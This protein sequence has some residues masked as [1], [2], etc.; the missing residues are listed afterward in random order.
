MYAIILD[1]N[2]QYLIKENTL[3]KIDFLNDSIGNK[4][5]I[6]KILFLNNNNEIFI[7]KPFVEKKSLIF[8][9]VKQIKD[10]KKITLKFKR[11]KHHMKK[12]G[13][14]Q[15]YTILKFIGLKNII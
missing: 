7:G 11:R 9:I 5:E 4:I 13:H 2:K 12:I 14:R 6:N 15:K 3:L 8:E 10:K 1:R